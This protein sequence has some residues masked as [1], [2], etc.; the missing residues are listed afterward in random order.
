[1]FIY[2]YNIHI[3]ICIY[4]YMYVIYVCLSMYVY[5]CVKNLKS[6]KMILE[7]IFTQEYIEYR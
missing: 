7:Q 1:M 2:L 6:K 4:V 3:N 5:I